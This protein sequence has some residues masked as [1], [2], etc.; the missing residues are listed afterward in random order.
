MQT[1]QTFNR[2]QSHSV[3]KEYFLP[4]FS[5]GFYFGILSAEHGFFQ[6]KGAALANVAQSQSVH[7]KGGDG[8]CKLSLMESRKSTL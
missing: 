4:E 8:K 3:K 1:F 2:V 5:F 7:C 6:D